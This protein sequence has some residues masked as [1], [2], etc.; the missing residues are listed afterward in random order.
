MLRDKCIVVIF[1]GIL[2]KA[3]VL[4][5]ESL[6]MRMLYMLCL[7]VGEDSGQVIGGCAHVV[8]GRLFTYVKRC[9]LF[10]VSH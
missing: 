10:Q 4:N 1:V 3:F 2:R 5:T 8:S 7:L 9:L 6:M